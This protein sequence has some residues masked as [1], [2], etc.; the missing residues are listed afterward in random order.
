MK[1][2]A[3]GGTVYGLGDK[4]CPVSRWHTGLPL[5]QAPGPCWGGPWDTS[6]PTVR[7][8]PEGPHICTITRSR[9]PQE[10]L[11]CVRKLQ[12]TRKHLCEKPQP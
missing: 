12:E 4:L 3:F 8:G 5:G 10:S 7:R 1:S 2:V 6:A 11:W 9:F